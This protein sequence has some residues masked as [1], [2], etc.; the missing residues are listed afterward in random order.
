LPAIL[1]RRGPGVEAVFHDLAV[2]GSPADFQ[3]AG[4]LL[5]VPVHALE[6]TDDVGPLGFGERRHPFTSCLDRGLGRVQELDVA[7]PDDAA[8]RRER[9]PGDG[10][11][12]LADIPWPV[13][14]H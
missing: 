4:R 12:E 5:L 14:L 9:R 6:H 10:A 2:E 11:L 7:G 8:W 13:I 1:W 3:H